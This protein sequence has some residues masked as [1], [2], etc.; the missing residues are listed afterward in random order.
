M[1][2]MTV[3]AIITDDERI[4]VIAPTVNE[5]VKYMENKI[6]NWLKE[7]THEVVTFVNTILL[8]YKPGCRG[9]VADE[10]EAYRFWEYNL[11]DMYET[12][13]DIT[14]ELVPIFKNYMKDK[15]YPFEDA[16]V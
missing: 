10:D 14:K 7:S 9:Y 8:D 13:I 3:I 1:R 5:A 2:N 6:D 4:D 12:P 15:G 16:T 11:K